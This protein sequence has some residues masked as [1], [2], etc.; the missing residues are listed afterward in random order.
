MSLPELRP[1][2]GPRPRS[3]IEDQLK[4]MRAHA[5][6]QPDGSRGYAHDPIYRASFVRSILALRQVL[7]PTL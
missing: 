5:R 4:A 1:F 3:H 7:R 6:R 2:I